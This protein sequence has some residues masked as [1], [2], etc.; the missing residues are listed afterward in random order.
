MT[1]TGRQL[2][3]QRRTRLSSEVQSTDEI[4][5]DTESLVTTTSSSEIFLQLDHDLQNLWRCFRSVHILAWDEVVIATIHTSATEEHNS[6]ELRPMELKQSE[7]QF[8]LPGIR[9]SADERMSWPF[10]LK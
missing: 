1:T 4:I 6:M 2:L 3:K 8:R 7:K 5:E 9:R 10:Q